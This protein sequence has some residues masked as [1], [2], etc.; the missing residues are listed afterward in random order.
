MQITYQLIHFLMQQRHY[1]MISKFCTF[2]NFFKIYGQQMLNYLKNQKK[3]NSLTGN[4][5][6]QSFR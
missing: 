1:I 5:M 6:A 2:L 3:K 4:M